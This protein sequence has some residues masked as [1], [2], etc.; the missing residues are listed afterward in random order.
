M[1]QELTLLLLAPTVTNPMEVAKTRLQLDGE[2]QGR[3]HLP[4]KVAAAAAAAPAAAGAA[5]VPEIP[6]SLKAGP[7][8]KVYTSALDCMQKTWRHEGLGGI[9]RGLGAAVRPPLSSSPL[10]PFLHL[11]CVLLLTT[12]S[13]A[14]T[15]RLPDRAQRLPVGLLR[16]VPARH[17]LARRV[18]Q[19][20][21]AR[22][23]EHHGRRKLWCRR[24][25]VLIPFL[26]EERAR[27]RES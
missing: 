15:V 26:R 1:P 16:A 17:Q 14:P 27:G 13:L 10:V 23:D 24:R 9:Q 12:S 4:P 7:S 18:R 6:P 22:M 20:R 11:L 21:D 5:A 3:A 25:Y 19:A 2:L 8:G